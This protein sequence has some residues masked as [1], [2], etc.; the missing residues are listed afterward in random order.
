MT[1]DPLPDVRT[2]PLSKL[3]DADLPD[4]LAWAIR[5]LAG[6]VAQPQDALA[7]FTSYVEGQ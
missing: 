1:P 6:E 7:A 3:L 2:V 5:R 4:V